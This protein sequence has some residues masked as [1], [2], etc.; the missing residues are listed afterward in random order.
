MMQKPNKIQTVHVEKLDN[1]VSV[2][3][4]QRKEVHNLNPTAARVW[5][6]CDGQT[7]PAQ[8]A[9]RLR[10]E[11]DTPY[12][13]DVVWLALKELEQAHLLENTDDQPFGRTLMSRRTLIKRMGVAAALLPV[14]VSI[15]TPGPVQ[16]QTPGDCTPNPNAET[17]GTWRPT[18]QGCTEDP[19]FDQLVLDQGQVLADLLEL[20]PCNGDYSMVVEV[21]IC[22]D[23][24]ALAAQ[25]N[26]DFYRYGAASAG[27]ARYLC[28]LIWCNDSET[29]S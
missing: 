10:A 15:V 8:I 14:V 26:A 6:L 27:E 20:C 29:P 13:E 23:C 18:S 2:Y 9:G 5:E 24:A 16:A 28:T 22:A 4:W 12:A 7:D 21:E 11:L 19:F 3:D 1:E 25:Q 17:I